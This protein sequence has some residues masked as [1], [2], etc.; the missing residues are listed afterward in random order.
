MARN[1]DWV[2]AGGKIGE[3]GWCTRCGEGLS[4]EMPQKV[5]VVVAAS[6]AFV[7]AHSTCPKEKYFERPAKTPG[8]WAVGRDTGTSSLTI[9]SAITGKR[10]P[11][12][13]F[14]APHDPDDFGRCYRLLKLFPAWRKDLGKTIEICPEWK[15]FVNAWDQ[16]VE[17]Y[18]LE[19][20][21]GKAPRLYGL[22]KQ[23]K[24]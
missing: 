16:L 6:R 1:I 11:D 5:E 9:Y 17:L 2:V 12:Q 13:D 14:D 19:L 8:E 4:I 15:P 23:L 18:E 22:I 10:L 7:K 20:Q 24:A 3:L 21:M